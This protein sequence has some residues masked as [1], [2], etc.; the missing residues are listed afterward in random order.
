MENFKELPLEVRLSAYLDGQLDAADAQEIET[1]LKSNPQAQD[2]LATLKAGSDFGNQAFEDM[3]NEPVP[4]H[5]VRSIKEAAAKPAPV[6]IA[7]NGNS[8]SFMRFVPQAIAACAVLLL[9]GGYSGYFLGQ[10]SVAEAPMEISETSAFQAPA[11]TKGVK[12]RGFTFEAPGAESISKSD[13]ALA[14]IASLHKVY[15]A[16]K[17]HADEVPAAQEDELKGYLEAVTSVNFSVPDLSAEGFKLRGGKLVVAVGQPTG[18]LFY[19][20]GQG[21]VV[22]V[23]FMKNADVTGAT[24]AKDGFSVVGGQKDATSYFIAAQDEAQARRFED[25]VRTAL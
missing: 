7:A 19:E 25:S 12:T 6:R 15:A 4:L 18:A 20:N 5:V 3:L 16:D 22:A 13:V 14:E 24:P 2:I 23:Y 9:A 17:T 11:E 1:L 8:I 21:N 10:R